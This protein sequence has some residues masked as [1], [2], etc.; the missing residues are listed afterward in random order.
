MTEQRAHSDELIHVNAAIKRHQRMLGTLFVRRYQL[1]GGSAKSSVK[2]AVKRGPK[3]AYCFE[4][5]GHDIAMSSREFKLIE[6]LNAV[7]DGE[8]LAAQV[9]L[10]HFNNSRTW[11]GSALQKLNARLYAADAR[12]EGVKHGGR[13]NAGYR[14]VQ[15]VETEGG[16][17]AE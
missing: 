14:L 4:I 3:Q 8:F 16:E 2:A 7:E 1:G 5:N 15:L 12:I 6:M 17:E 13:T 11:A 10:D 9:V